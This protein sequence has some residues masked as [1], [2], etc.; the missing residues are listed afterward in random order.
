M[1]ID[2][3][4]LLA[5]AL[6]FGVH[7]YK[8]TAGNR[9][10]DYYPN[11]VEEL[12]AEYVAGD[13]TLFYLPK[14]LSFMNRRHLLSLGCGLVCSLSGCLTSE[15]TTNGVDRIEISNKH[16]SELA[17]STTIQKNGNT[18]YDSNTTIAA[19]DDVNIKK[20]WMNDPAEYIITVALS[21][22]TEE[23]LGTE[24]LN[25]RYELGDRCYEFD[26]V[27]DSEVK[28]RPHVGSEPCDTQETASS[29]S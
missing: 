9:F 17:V 5:A 10:D 3:T 25:K 23:T 4:F 13:L 26:F 20:E 12:R 16:S 21:N 22:G 29:Q 24:D 6:W 28:I 1:N 19:G 7:V 14:R 27:I 11:R 15:D 18:E 2:P 8:R